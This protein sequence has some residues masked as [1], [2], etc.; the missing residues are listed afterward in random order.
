MESLKNKILKEGIVKENN[1]L[2]VDNFLNH[3]LDIEFLNEIGKEIG[4]RF[5][6]E[7]IDKI[8]TIEA[9][10][11]AIAAIASQYFGNVPVV[12]AKKVQSLNLDDS[13]YSSKVFSYTK[14]IQ[15]D[16]MV[17]KRY[18]SENE[19]ILIIDD[20][21]AN[22]QAILALID[23][24]EKAKSKVVGISIVVEKSFQ[25]GANKIKSK[26]YRLESLAKIKSLDKKIEFI[27]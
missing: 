10:G 24:I 23:I 26:G 25:D 5:K 2:K 21:L 14:N 3:Q 20:F 8:L 1:V 22:G 19:N 9:S 27:D 18:I 4:N 11:I 16:V 13:I 6:N 17:S 15:Y 7:K 12:F